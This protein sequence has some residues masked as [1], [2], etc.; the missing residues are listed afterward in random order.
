[1]LLSVDLQVGHFI[2]LMLSRP[3]ALRHSSKHTLW[4]VWRHGKGT[5]GCPSLANGWQQIAQNIAG[6]GTTTTLSSARSNP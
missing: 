1:M 6:I 3:R 4:N 2:A 5:V